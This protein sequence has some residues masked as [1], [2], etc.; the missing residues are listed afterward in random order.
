MIIRFEYRKITKKLWTT[1]ISV[2]RLWKRMYGKHAHRS[3]HNVEKSFAVRTTVRRILFFFLKK[4]LFP[5]TRAQ[6]Q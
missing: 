3:Y 5:S 4:N 1:K 2:M 6:I